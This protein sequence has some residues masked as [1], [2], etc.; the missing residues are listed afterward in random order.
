MDECV[1]VRCGAG[2]V[3][4][5]GQT[6]VGGLQQLSLERLTMIQATN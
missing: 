6:S 5:A 3:I 2:K 4:K 1:L